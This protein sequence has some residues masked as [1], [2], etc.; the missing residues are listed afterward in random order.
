MSVR[1]LWDASDDVACL[2]DSVSGE[3]FG[4]LFDAPGGYEHAERFLDWL[5]AKKLDAR[6]VQ[7]NTLRALR[8]E[9]LDEQPLVA[10]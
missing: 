2:Y 5:A 3:A 8:R 7:P 1:I 6:A 4:Q 9:F 10:A